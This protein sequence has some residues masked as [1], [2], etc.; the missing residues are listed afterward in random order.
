MEGLPKEIWAV[1]YRFGSTRERTSFADLEDFCMKWEQD[2]VL[3][4]LERSTLFRWTGIALSGT[5]RT[6]PSWWR[7]FHAN[8]MDAVMEAAV[9]SGSRILFRDH[10]RFNPSGVSPPSFRQRLGVVRVGGKYVRIAE[11]GET[12]WIID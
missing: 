2:R 12:M 1:I 10:V 5:I 3:V 6:K 11:M 9:R 4:E 7:W 8:L